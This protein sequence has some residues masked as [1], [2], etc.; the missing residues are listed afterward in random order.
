[1][2]AE[3]EKKDG[4]YVTFG[5][6]L[7]LPSLSKEEAENVKKFIEKAKDLKEVRKTIENLWVIG[8]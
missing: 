8:R 7:V 2:K 5:Q 4:Y 1:M 6:H 3:I